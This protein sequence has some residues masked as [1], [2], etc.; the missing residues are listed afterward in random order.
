MEGA[1]TSEAIGIKWY[2]MMMIMMANDIWG[3]MGPK[4]S[5]HLSYSWGK[6]PEKTSIRKTDPA[7]D[8]DLDFLRHSSALPMT[9]VLVSIKDDCNFVGII[10]ARCSKVYR[11]IT[12]HKPHTTYRNRSSSV[13]D[14]SRSPLYLFWVWGRFPADTIA[15]VKFRRLDWAGT[16]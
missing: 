7:G 6:I 9:Q 14:H 1:W 10:N 8:Q 2:V 16:S 15:A 4:F 13:T 3:W 11:A 5:R 12:K